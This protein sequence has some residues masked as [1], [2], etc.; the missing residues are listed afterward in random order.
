MGFGA[1]EKWVQVLALPWISFLNCISL[2]N[3]IYQMGTVKASPLR[4]YT[5]LTLSIQ[6]AG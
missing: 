3:L 1:R 2:N 6:I 4:L 5:L